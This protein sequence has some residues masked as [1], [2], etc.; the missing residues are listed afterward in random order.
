[1]GMFKKTLVVWVFSAKLVFSA[2]PI[3]FVKLTL[4]EAI[5]RALQHNE[6]VRIARA[7]VAQS[8]AAYG[9]ARAGG[10][11]RADLSVGYSRSWLLPTVVFDTPTGRQ[12]LNIGTDN[13]VTGNLLL[14]QTLY[15]GGRITAS[16]SSARN[17]TRYAL[18]RE[19]SIQQ[20]ARALVEE[21]F[22]AVVLGIE[23]DRVSASALARARSSL[24]QVTALRR[25]GRA[26]E[27]DLV[28]A[29]VQINV[30]QNDSIDVRNELDMSR[31]DLKRLV[32]IDLDRDVALVGG[33]DR[34]S[35]VPTDSLGKLIT[36]ALHQRP[37]LQQLGALV[38]ARRRDVDT[39]RA[40]LRPEL[41]LVANGQMQLQSD[42]F[43]VAG[44]E[45]RQ[46]WSTGLSLTFP[47]FD[48]LLTRS[49]VEEARIELRKSELEKQRIAKII[50]LEVKQ[51]WLDLRA[52]ESRRATQRGAL[53]L[54]ERGL[55]MAQSRYANGLG[56]QLEL[57]DAQLMIR[58]SEA[59]LA[60]AEHDK[61]VSVVKLEQAVGLLSVE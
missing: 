29:R 37:E 53:A 49:K 16:R 12:R 33:F 11:P 40:G 19:R 9:Q 18:A 28:R 59:D 35:E 26:L 51:A 14:S 57:L 43:D 6:E 55:S 24:S 13:S 50:A 46:S 48:G 4:P 25:A 15:S 39:E 20:Q 23:L 1:V 41:L 61:A 10:L 52:S 54:A 31:A 8:K 5:E 36:M 27:Y 3:E 30:L 60:T 38:R 45:W 56:T 22:F 58:Q 21:R 44:E 32:G 47:L 34:D 17:L 42:S 7:D 2:E